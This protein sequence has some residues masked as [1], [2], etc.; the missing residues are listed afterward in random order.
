MGF[1]GSAGGLIIYQGHLFPL[2]GHLLWMDQILHH[3]RSHGNHIVCWYLQGNH[4]KPG[5]LRCVGWISQ[6]IHSMVACR[7]ARRFF[8]R[9]GAEA[10][11][12][13]DFEAKL[14]RD[15]A[16]LPGPLGNHGPSSAGRVPVVLVAGMRD[17]KQTERF[18]ARPS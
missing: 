14:G 5:C 18:Y 11:E 2:K 9:I 6:P 17:H 12:R 4:Q 16:R 13:L 15:L 7:A 1:P 10:R 3:L 8:R